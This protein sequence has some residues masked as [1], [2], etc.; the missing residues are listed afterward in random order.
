MGT[1]ASAAL[2]AG[3]AALVRA[4]HPTWTPDQVTAALRA[5]AN[6]TASLPAA[7]LLNPAGLIP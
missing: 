4:A 5:A 1:S 7:P 6:P 2:A 3:A